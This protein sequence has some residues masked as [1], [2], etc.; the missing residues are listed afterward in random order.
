[1][2]YTSAIFLVNND[3]RAVSTSY[4]VDKITGK[5]I[6]PFVVYKTFDKQLGPGDLVVVPTDTRHG[7]TVV[8]IEEVDLEVDLDSPTQ[9]RWIVGPVGVADFKKVVAAETQVIERIKSAEVKAKKQ[10]LADKLMA[11]NPEISLLSNVG[12]QTLAA[13][14]PDVMEAPGVFS[15]APDDDIPY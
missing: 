3:V 5:G 12:A 2:N 4:E 9:L 7:Y 14:E 11:D 15:P 1:M 10:A 13:P 6:G 8:R